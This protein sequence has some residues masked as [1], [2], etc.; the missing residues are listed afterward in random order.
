M[1]RDAKKK[2]AETLHQELQKARGV[3]LSA[4]EGITVAQ[5]FELRR[6]VAQA[7]ATYKAVVVEGKVVSLAELNSLASLPSKEALSSKVLFLINS[8]AQRV[9]SA[10]AGV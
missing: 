8:P 7:G 6:K 4:F 2:Q 1:D 3:I 5:D 9:A 10:I